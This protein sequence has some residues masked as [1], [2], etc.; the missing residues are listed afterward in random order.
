MGL[1]D[2][3]RNGLAEARWLKRHR[4]RFCTGAQVF[5]RV[6]VHGPCLVGLCFVTSARRCAEHLVGIGLSFALPVFG[7]SQSWICLL[8]DCILRTRAARTLI[9][10]RSFAASR[11]RQVCS[12]RG[13]RSATHYQA[14]LSAESILRGQV[15]PILNGFCRGG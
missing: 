3:V 2:Q 9:V 12:R 15:S 14:K 11:P 10:V 5:N 13:C 4:I 8:C 1:F 6:L 7:C